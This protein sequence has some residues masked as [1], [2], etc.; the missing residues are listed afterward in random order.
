M[1]HMR[2]AFGSPNWV[3][4]SKGFTNI[5]EE[6]TMAPVVVDG[7]KNYQRKVRVHNVAAGLA[8]TFTDCRMNNK[9]LANDDLFEQVI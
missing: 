7:N 8:L 2:L 4:R 6:P 1:K 3:L 5:S 9:A